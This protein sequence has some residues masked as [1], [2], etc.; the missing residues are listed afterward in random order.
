M[1]KQGQQRA[2]TSRMVYAGDGAKSPGCAWVALRCM[3]MKGTGNRV[4]RVRMGDAPLHDTHC[5]KNQ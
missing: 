5:H 4:T 3:R 2:K 1:D